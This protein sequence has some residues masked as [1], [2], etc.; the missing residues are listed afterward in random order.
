[1][2]VDLLAMRLGCVSTI[3]SDV[4]ARGSA[5]QGAAASQSDRGAALGYAQVFTEVVNVD[6]LT[7]RHRL[8][9]NR[10]QVRLT[11][12]RPFLG[13]DMVCGLGN[14]SPYGYG[15]GTHRRDFHGPSSM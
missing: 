8:V 7:R 11:K 6:R 10:G 4:T 13:S 1:M 2:N 14:L 9:K 5:F 3:S 12:R 15:R